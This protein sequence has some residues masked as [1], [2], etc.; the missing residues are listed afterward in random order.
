MEQE[1]SGNKT[2]HDAVTIIIYFLSPSMGKK[3]R[4]VSLLQLPPTLP[5]THL[6]VSLSL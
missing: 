4:K 2:P 1:D 5:R 6:S 3:Y